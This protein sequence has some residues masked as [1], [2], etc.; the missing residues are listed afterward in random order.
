MATQITKDASDSRTTANG[1][2]PSAPKPAA[3]RT[4]TKRASTTTRK[5]KA[6][7]KAKAA[8]TTRKPAARKAT[9]PVGKRIADTLISHDVIVGAAAAAAGVLAGLAAVV[10]RKAATQAVAAFS[11][12]WFDTL[13]A[14]HKTAFGIFDKLQ[15]TTDAQVTKRAT[16]LAQLKHALAKHAFEEENV[17]Y[18][19]L[20]DEARAEMADHL[21]HDHGYV[22]QYLH[23]LDSMPKNGA[24]FLAKVAEFRAALEKHVR[25]E[26]DEVYPRLRSGLS[27]EENARL[28]TALNRE[29]FKLA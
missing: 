22:K 15:A 1:A 25:E 21:N 20:R 27:V 29:G 18:P 19:A 12:D 26:E 24:A 3:K 7:T 10:G 23:D 13:K 9:P 16:L 28:T 6:A 17:V 8:S 11:G 5:P 2:A 14:E 4:T